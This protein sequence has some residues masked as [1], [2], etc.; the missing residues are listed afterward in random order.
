MAYNAPKRD[1]SDDLD[2]DSKSAISSEL[3]DYSCVS[4]SLDL[5]GTRFRKTR[6]CEQRVE[7]PFLTRLQSFNSGIPISDTK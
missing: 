1:P 3:E 7:P 6:T 2:G 4:N 5:L